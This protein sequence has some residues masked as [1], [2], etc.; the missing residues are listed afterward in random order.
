MTLH[1]G[2][3]AKHPRILGVREL[4]R[5]DLATLRAAPRVVPK[6][7]AFRDTHHRMARLVAAGLRVEEIL[8]ITG[9]SYQRLWVLQQDPAFQEL[10]AQYRGKVDE[11]FERS[12]DEFYATSVSNMLR[13][14]RQ[15]EEHLDK[16][17]EAGELVPLKTLL[18]ITSDRADRFGY[19]KRS[20]QTNVKV[21]VG[22]MMESALTRAGRSTVIDGRVP[23]PTL[24]SPREADPSSPSVSREP[25]GQHQQ[26]NLLRTYSS[27]GSAMDGA[28]VRTAESPRDIPSAVGIRRRG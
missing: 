23:S 19:G 28:G 11:A 13:A 9:Y 5:E 15:V 17:D 10:V 1:R 14:E 21:D 27:H 16:A 6:V 22:R 26:S 20:I 2:K 18:A 7:K 8:R 4:T 3:L 25:S 12:Q 24:P